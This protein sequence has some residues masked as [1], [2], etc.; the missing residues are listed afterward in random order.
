MVLSRCIICCSRRDGD[1]RSIYVFDEW[2]A[3]QDPHYREIL[4]GS[5]PS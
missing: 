1:D 2:A 3:D 5:C 4:R